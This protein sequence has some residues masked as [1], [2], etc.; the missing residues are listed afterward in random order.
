MR[1]VPNQ[2]EVDDA[3]H[4]FIGTCIENG[5]PLDG[6]VAMILAPEIASGIRFD[7]SV[8]GAG[9]ALRGGEWLCVMS[10][11]CARKLLEDPAAPPHFALALANLPAEGTTGIVPVFHFFDDGVLSSKFVFVAAFGDMPV[12]EFS[13]AMLAAVQAA[14]PEL[15]RRIA[16]GVRADD[17]VLHLGLRT[18]RILR[19]HEALRAFKG[20]ARVSASLRAAVVPGSVHGI[21]HVAGGRI[22]AGHFPLVNSG[23]GDA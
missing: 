9:I 13:S 12:D 14:R 16:M 23:G 5:A 1:H 11:R 2:K 3:L 10:L 17:L 7:Q 18:L 15:Q 20:N 21:V 22:V 6:M 19:R 8:F 4:D